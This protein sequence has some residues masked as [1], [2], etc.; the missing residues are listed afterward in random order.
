[1]KRIAYVL[2][3]VLICSF[4]YF[5]FP[6]KS[7]AC[8]CMKA[9]PEERLQKTDVVFEGKVLEVQKKDGKM[10]ILFEV[11]RIWKGTSSSQIII[12]TSFSSCTFP[13]GE[14]GEYLVFAFNRGE[15]KLET[16][17]CSGTKRLDEA[18]ADKVALS[19]IA[20]ES[21]P[22]KKVNLKNDMVSGFSWWQVVTLS[23]GLLLIVALA[24]I[25]VRR[26]RKK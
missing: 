21:V 11:K 18:G 24:I 17:M 9:S 19:Q 16:S 23:I 6:E 14:E 4:T 26:T 25:I 8:E 20:K 5:I 15:G 22:T 1:M 3:L 10:E 2:S 12:Y 7:Y 13:F